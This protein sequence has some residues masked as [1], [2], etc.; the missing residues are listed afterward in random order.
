MLICSVGQW[1]HSLY[2][3]LLTLLSMLFGTQNMVNAY[4]SS[5]SHHHRYHYCY[6]MNRLKP[7]LPPVMNQHVSP[8]GIKTHSFKL[9][10]HNKT[11]EMA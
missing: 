5:L 7:Q 10:L 2:R 1:Q 3:V 11:L 6:Q 9:F 4:D 8:K